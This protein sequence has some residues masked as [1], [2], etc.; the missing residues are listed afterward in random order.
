MVG[1]NLNISVGQ[2]SQEYD[3]II[4]KSALRNDINGDYVLIIESKSTP[5]GN[6]FIARR[7]DIQILAQDD[8]QAAVSGALN[9][10]QDY[11]I[12]T[13]SGPIEAGSQVRITEN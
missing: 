8:N 1:Q 4:P 11:V 12:T 7:V 5:L 3:C 13:A 10:W 2:R 6:R 9:T